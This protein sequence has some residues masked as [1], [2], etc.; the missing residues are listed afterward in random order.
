MQRTP[1]IAASAAALLGFAALLTAG[2]LSPPGGPVASTYKTLTDVEPRIPISAA[3]TPGDASATFRISQP[4]SYYLTGNVNAQSGKSGIAVDAQGVTLDLRGFSVTGDGSLT[5]S[6]FGILASTGR[7][8]VHDGTVQSWPA[9]GIYIQFPGSNCRFDRIVVASNRGAG[10]SV[11]SAATVND[12]IA[13]GNS[14]SGFESATGSVFSRCTAS[15]NATGGISSGP[16]GNGFT[17]GQYCSVRDC[18]AYSN[19][20]IG[21]GGSGF[22][23]QI[24]S[25][26]EH[27]IANENGT[28]TSGDGFTVG[29]GVQI[30]DC[31]AE[32]NAIDGIRAA[33]TSTIRNNTCV[34]NGGAGIHITSAFALVAD[35]FCVNGSVG[36]QADFGYNTFCRNFATNNVT[37]W[38]LVA[39]NNANVV[40]RSGAPAI[41]GNA[42][43]T[44][45]P[46]TDPTTNFTLVYP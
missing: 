20:R 5:G 40:L 23:A 28:S 10:I 25:V 32:L 22:T 14:L 15:A 11:G 30:S 36:Y 38:N 21:A 9:G 17:L 19:G 1:V 35:N 2:P 33:G 4:G 3:T 39:L 34:A 43:G 26:L 44:A 45:I 27:C 29:P 24:G 16:Q 46:T 7:L 6:T 18:I 12:C 13:S 41:T 8:T 37:N 42:G 31:T